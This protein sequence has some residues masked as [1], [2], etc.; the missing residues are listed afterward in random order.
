[1]LDQWVSA[2]EVCSELVE[3]QKK[4]SLE[5]KKEVSVAPAAATT[6]I[7]ALTKIKI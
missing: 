4:N 6:K 7:Q 2:A 3:S 5:K 1:M